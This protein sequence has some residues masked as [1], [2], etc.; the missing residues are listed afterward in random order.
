[1]Y[2]TLRHLLLPGFF[3]LVLWGSLAVGA[4]AAT[5]YVSAGGHN[6]SPSDNNSGTTLAQPFATGQKYANV[7]QPGDTCFVRG[8]TYALALNTNFVQSVRSGTA[9][10]PITFKAY[11]GETPTITNA[12]DNSSV[13]NNVS[14]I[15]FFIYQ[16]SYIIVDG[17]TI[18]GG[19]AGLLA[20]S[21]ANFVQFLNNTI[22]FS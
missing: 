7:A 12:I 1:M 20:Y 19:D 18:I 16:H 13:H 2:K 6:D 14:N 17:F 5:Y 9:L 4:Q 8:G 11:S 22:S 15:G 21:G 10:A 3:L